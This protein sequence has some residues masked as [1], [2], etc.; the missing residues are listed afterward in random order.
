MADLLTIIKRKY[1]FQV[2]VLRSAEVTIYAIH[3]LYL[4]LYSMVNMCIQEGD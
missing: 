4:S 3:C 1:G 2:Q